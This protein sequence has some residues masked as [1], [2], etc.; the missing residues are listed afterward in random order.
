MEYRGNLCRCQDYTKILDAMMRG[1]QY[2]KTGVP[3]DAGSA[4]G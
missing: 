1:A 3:A 4:A 2:T